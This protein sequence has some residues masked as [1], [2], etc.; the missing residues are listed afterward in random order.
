[1]GLTTGVG[2]SAEDKNEWN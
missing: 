2:I 1:M